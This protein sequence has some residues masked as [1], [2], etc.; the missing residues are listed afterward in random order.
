MVCQVRGCRIL[1][2]GPRESMALRKGVGKRAWGRKLKRNG[3]G[4]WRKRR[5]NGE[6]AEGYCLGATCVPQ[7]PSV[8][9]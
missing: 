2:G 7:S 1:G 6:V 4:G 5:G 8:H 9:L 3:V